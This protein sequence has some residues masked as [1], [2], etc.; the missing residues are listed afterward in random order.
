MPSGKSIKNLRILHRYMGLFFAPSILFFAFS[1]GLQVFNLHKPDKSAGYIPPAW[2]LEMAQVHKSQT[3]SISKKNTKTVQADPGSDDSETDKHSTQAPKS[4]LPLQC[5]FVVMSAGLMV[6]TLLGI[7][8]AF[9]FGGKPWLIWISLL[10]GTAI[11]IAMLV[12]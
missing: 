3:L 9:L 1:G 11:P 6:T 7:Y 12:L 4:K 5:F 8:M 10:A 2:I